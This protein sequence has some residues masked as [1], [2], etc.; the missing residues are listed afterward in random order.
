[1]VEAIFTIDEQN[2]FINEEARL[3][4]QRPSRRASLISKKSNYKPK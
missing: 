2:S 3:L 4:S 1:M